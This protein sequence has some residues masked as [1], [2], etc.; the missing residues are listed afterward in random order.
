M[1]YRSFVSKFPRAILWLPPDTVL[2]DHQTGHLLEGNG[3]LTRSSRHRWL[4]WHLG[5]IFWS[6]FWSNYARHLI[7]QIPTLSFPLQSRSLVYCTRSCDV[8]RKTSIFWCR[9]VQIYIQAKND[10]LDVIKSRFVC[11]RSAKRFVACPKPQNLDEAFI[12]LNISP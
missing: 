3:W 8:M 9:C 10:N 7:S 4:C 1:R 6:C 12:T 2:A 5:G 11:V